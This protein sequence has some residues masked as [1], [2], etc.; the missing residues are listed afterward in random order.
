MA[1]ILCS[2][3]AT[4]FLLMHRMPI[5]TYWIYWIYPSFPAH[6]LLTLYTLFFAPDI[7]P[8]LPSA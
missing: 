2:E 8:H 3:Q 4:L 6:V 1:Q 5:K 7:G